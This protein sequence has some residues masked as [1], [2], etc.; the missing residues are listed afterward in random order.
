MVD[1]GTLRL[2]LTALVRKRKEELVPR[3]QSIAASGWVTLA[4]ALAR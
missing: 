3:T 1:R 4:Y 2:L